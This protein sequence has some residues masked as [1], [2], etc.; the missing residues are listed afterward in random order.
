MSII[1]FKIIGGASEVDRRQVR[2]TQ[3]GRGPAKE[4]LKKHVNKSRRRS[5]LTDQV[6]A[7]LG[8]KPLRPEKEPRSFRII[9]DRDAIDKGQKALDESKKIENA[10]IRRPHSKR[11]NVERNETEVYVEKPVMYERKPHDTTKEKKAERIRD[12]AG[13]RENLLPD[14]EQPFDKKRRPKREKLSKKWRRIRD[15]RDRR[16][17]QRDK[18]RL[19]KF[20][21]PAEKRQ[22]Q[23]AARMPMTMK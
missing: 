5:T 3:N 23:V 20:I 17:V 21:I 6:Q 16:Q 7:A 18:S 11:R 14:M 10:V 9:K 1:R 2:S 13:E 12:K 8:I 22:R 15:G 4:F 19:S